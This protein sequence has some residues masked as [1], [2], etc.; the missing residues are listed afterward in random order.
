M[1][2]EGVRL[3]EAL[4]RAGGFTSAAQRDDIRVIR[5]IDGQ[6][7]MFR[8]DFGRII[9]GDL[10]QN[11]TLQT[12]DVVYVPRSFLGDVNDVIAKIEPL[13]NIL[14]LPATYRDLYT[15]GGGLRLDTGVLARK[16]G[17]SGPAVVPGP[18]ST[19]SVGQ[20]AASCTSSVRP[21][22]WEEAP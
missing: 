17:E 22:V 16:G 1:F 12:E 3:V 20:I 4:S 13:L 9:S 21:D 19:P 8:L 15:T 11:V 14:L 6:P 2:S 7:S 10:R 5:V 18:T